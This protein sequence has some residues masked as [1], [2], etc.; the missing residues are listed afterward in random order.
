MLTSFGTKGRHDIVL[1]K[2]SEFHELGSF[3]SCNAIYESRCQPGP[4]LCS[5]GTWVRRSSKNADPLAA[6]NK[7]LVHRP[8]GPKSYTC[9]Q[10]TG[11]G[12]LFTQILHSFLH[13]SLFTFLKKI[14]I[15]LF[16]YLMREG[17]KNYLVDSWKDN[18]S[19][20]KI[21]L[22]KWQ[23]VTRRI[24]KMEEPEGCRKWTS[25]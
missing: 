21:T 13:L 5:A 20:R 14:F 15:W 25:F 10:E 11:T 23:V 4:L 1:Y 22:S 9:T 6:I 2:R 24:E 7:V 3:L 18:Q 17:T 12:N 16:I 19:N 8:R